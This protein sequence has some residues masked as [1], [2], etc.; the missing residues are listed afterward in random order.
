MKQIKE[1][2]LAIITVNYENYPVTEEFLESFEKQSDQN[3]VVYIAD[4]SN[5]KQKIKE[6][7]FIRI[8]QGENK[9]YAH[10][11]NLGLKQAIG[12][13]LSRFAIINNDTEVDV[14]FSN[15]VVKS[16]DKNKKASM[17]GKIYYFS[18][19]EYHKSRY[20]KDDLGKVFWYAGGFVDWNHATVHHR[21]VDEVDT[22]QYNQ[23]EE[24]GFVTG[25]LTCF[26]KD[27]LDKVGFWDESYF[28]YYEDA[29][30]CER[31]KRR[32]I[33]LYYDPSIIIWHKNAQSTG[34]SGSS[35]HQKYQESSRRRFAMKYAPLKTK[36]H[37]LKN[38]LIKTK[39]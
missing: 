33:K 8:I 5:T 16:I 28:L 2:E 25:C 19:Y 21:G 9:G 7:P 13:G 4:I 12:N 38:R 39:A 15:N 34:G 29:D 37:L 10:G 22:D 11:V 24:T 6:R 23:F 30:W 32:G 3:F 31:A 27:V 14:K 17:G 20:K 1:A 26:D 18:G 36:L 35:L